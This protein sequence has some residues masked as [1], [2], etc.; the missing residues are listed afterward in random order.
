MKR[1][2]YG[3]RQSTRSFYNKLD[4]VLKKKGYVRIMVPQNVQYGSLRFSATV[5]RR[6]VV[7]LPPQPVSVNNTLQLFHLH[8]S[9]LTC[10]DTK[11]KHRRRPTTARIYAEYSS[12]IINTRD[13]RNTRH[14][15]TR[16]KY[17]LVTSIHSLDL[18]SK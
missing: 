14:K 18:H 17:I 11:S 12:R 10:C 8:I 15:H 6:P 9:I 3:L 13:T 2:L 5:S 16:Y 7:D 1:S 4:S